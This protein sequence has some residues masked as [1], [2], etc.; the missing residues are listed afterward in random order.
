MREKSG[1]CQEMCLHRRDHDIALERKK[2]R[3]NGHFISPK[4]FFFGKN[5]AVSSWET[6]VRAISLH[7][8][9]T[10][11]GFRLAFG[12]IIPRR[13]LEQ[14]I[15][16]LLSC[17]PP[18]ITIL[19]LHNVLL[20]SPLYSSF[21][22]HFLSQKKKEKKVISLS[23]LGEKRLSSPPKAAKRRRRRRRRM[24]TMAP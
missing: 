1:C 20:S 10:E 21:R 23:F 4:G 3:T 14:K 12:I 18:R 8:W 17:T 6:E 7:D 19:S 16:S 24:K 9:E 5:Q 11:L 22:L 13:P 2:E 15:F